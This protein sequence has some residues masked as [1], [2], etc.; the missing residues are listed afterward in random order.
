MAEESRQP[1]GSSSDHS[2]IEWQFRSSDLDAVRHWLLGG[3]IPSPFSVTDPESTDYGDSYYD[4]DDWHL[5]RAGFSLRIR[6]STDESEAILKANSQPDGNLFCR[7]EITERLPY[8]E[9]HVFR[10]VQGPVSEKIR[11]L[12][13]IDGLREIFMIGTHRQTFCLLHNGEPF[14]A[15]YLD[16][17]VLPLDRG[18]SHHR[19]LRVEVGTSAGRSAEDL[20]DFVEALRASCP[21]NPIPQTKYELG[22]RVRGLKP[23]GLPE[24]GSRQVDL[25]MSVGEVAFAVLRKHFLKLLEHEPGTRLGED[26]EELHDMRVASR[27]LRAAIS[28]FREHLPQRVLQLRP[29]LRRIGSALGEIRDLDVQIDELRS[30]AAP[31]PLEEPASLAPVLGILEGQREK[32]RRRM[33]RELDATRTA[34]FKARMVRALREGPPSRH[35]GARIPAV[36]VAP[37]LIRGRSRKVRKAGSRIGA[38]SQ[39]GEYHA[40]RIRCKRLRYALEFLLDLYGAPAKKLIRPVV[41]LQDL[42][43]LHQDAYVAIELMQQ[44]RSTKGRRLPRETLFVIGQIAHDY[45]LRAVT[46]RGRYPAA[47]RALYGKK[48]KW[49][50]LRDAMAHAEKAYM[51]TFTI[52]TLRPMRVQEGESD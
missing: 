40:L 35:P 32:A 19:E 21:V 37:L 28:L 13:A 5:Y 49:K 38:G 14:G 46:L 30:W 45:A 39:P 26:P 8:G 24:L 12:G 43:G 41:Y 52:H 34:S 29:G 36:A 44:L 3:L 4:T 42:L 31:R 11:C 50:K 16:E 22:I 20:Q 1:T 33:L 9:R 51:R 27:R 25:T 10:H 7:R 48:R 23:E 18:G 2:D 17:I 6:R 15:V 47:Y